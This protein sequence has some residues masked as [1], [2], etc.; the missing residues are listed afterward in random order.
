V[1]RSIE[2]FIEAI[3]KD[4]SSWHP[5]EPKWF[6]GEPKSDKP[7]LPTLYREGLARHENALLQMFRARASGFYDEVPDRANTDQWLF[8]ARHAGLPTRLLDWTE[9]ALI[10]LHFALKVDDPVV[11]M[12][13]PLEMN[14]LSMPS[15]PG[16]LPGPSRIREF[17]LPWHDPDPDPPPWFP[18]LRPRAATNPAFKNLRGAWEQDR[19]GVD[20]PVAIYPTYVHPRLR[21][22]RSC[23]TIHGKHKQGLDSLVPDSILKRYAVD[24]TCCQSMLNE[25]RLLGITDSSAFPDLDGLA[26]ELKTQFL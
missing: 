7:L 23:F 14:R 8:L 9:G 10:G 16:M 19:H 25:L 4:S 24:P 26:S 13:N 11:W 21:A 15:D 22:Q 6:R 12:L 2:D 17:P 20:L 18:R 1:I 3:R 5:K